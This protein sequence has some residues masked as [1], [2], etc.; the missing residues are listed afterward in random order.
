VVGPEGL[1]GMLGRLGLH[2]ILDM[3][4][5]HY[6]SF[7][8]VD[9]E[10]DTRNVRPGHSDCDERMVRLLIGTQVYIHHTTT[11]LQRDFC[12]G[13]LQRHRRGPIETI[14]V[15]AGCPRAAERPS[16]ARSEIRSGGMSPKAEYPQSSLGPCRYSLKDIHDICYAL[17]IDM[18]NSMQS[19]CCSWSDIIFA[20]IVCLLHAVVYIF[21]IKWCFL[22]ASFSENFYGLKRRRRPWIETERAKAAV[23]GIPVKE[24]LRSREVWRSL[25]FLVGIIANPYIITV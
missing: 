20:S 10:H 16:P 14:Y 15:R 17:S 23:G 8:V 6:I 4:E 5:L 21:S 24:K 12:H 18:R 9:C 19:L 13:I 7:V 1:P 3:K 11:T 2:N 25:V 22:D